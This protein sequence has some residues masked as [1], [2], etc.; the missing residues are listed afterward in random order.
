MRDNKVQS[1]TRAIA[2][3]NIIA[4]HPHGIGV[5]DL[6]RQADLHKSTVS[7]LMM[8]LEAANAVE[9]LAESS[10]VHIHPAFGQQLQNGDRSSSLLQIVRPTLRA[11]SQ[12]YDEATAIC[13]LESD[14]ALFLEQI[15][16]DKAIQVRDWTGYR[17]PLHT[18][19]AGRLFL[20][21]MAP[22]QLEHYLSQPLAKYTENTLTAPSKIRAALPAVRNSGVAWIRDEFAEGLSAVAAPIVDRHQ[23][24]VA[25]L[26]LFGPSFR[27]PGSQTTEPN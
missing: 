15:S 9:R 14:Q 10:Q 20:A 5:S 2:L 25:A 18:V 23:T 17:F 1:V 13:T 4:E 3:L 22:Q 16:P 12:E 21:H 24:V 26:V 6:A 7:R 11:L 8:T 19:S 27:F